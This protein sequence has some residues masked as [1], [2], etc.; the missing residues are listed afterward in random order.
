MNAFVL[1]SLD[2][3][4]TNTAYSVDTVEEIAVAKAEMVDQGIPTLPVWVGDPEGDH[5]RNGQRLF[6]SPPK[7]RESVLF[8][9]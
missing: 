2:N 6:V 8:H 9:A 7:V 1:I 5:H 4:N 3:G